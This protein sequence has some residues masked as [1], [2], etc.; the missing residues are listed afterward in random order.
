M[1]YLVLIEI[2]LFYGILDFCGLEI[3]IILR[4][5]FLIIKFK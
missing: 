3:Y 4:I 5:K 1:N 2:M